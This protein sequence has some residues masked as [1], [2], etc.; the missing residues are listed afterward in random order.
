MSTSMESGV[1]AELDRGAAEGE[2]DAPLLL[3]M[4]I[5]YWRCKEEREE[6][7]VPATD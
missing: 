2:G 5:P 6:G 1:A 3:Q 4:F 7:E